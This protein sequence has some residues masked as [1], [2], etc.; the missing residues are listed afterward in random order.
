MSAV[1]WDDLVA[2][3]FRN[4]ARDLQNWAEHRYFSNGEDLVASISRDLQKA[5]HRSLTTH[6]GS[7]AAAAR[8]STARHGSGVH[9]CTAFSL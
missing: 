9:V 1:P 5:E 4:G 2:F 6:N 7:V 8:C 3:H